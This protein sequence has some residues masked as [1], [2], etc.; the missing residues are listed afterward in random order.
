MT[1]QMMDGPP[2]ARLQATGFRRCCCC[3]DAGEPRTASVTGSELS[4]EEAGP[5][6]LRPA[7][8]RVRW[9]GICSAL[10]GFNLRR[11]SR[12]AQPGVRSAGFRDTWP[13]SCLAPLRGRKD[14]LTRLLRWTGRRTACL[15]PAGI[16]RVGEEV[17]ATASS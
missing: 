11:S 1:D 13:R 10:R 14:M 2:V 6:G 7:P 8:A 12:T 4:E 16:F 9:A 15:T 3:C 5:R 17:E